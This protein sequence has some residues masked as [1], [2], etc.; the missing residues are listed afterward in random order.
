[1]YIDIPD[2]SNLM[3]KNGYWLLVGLLFFYVLSV[4]KVYILAR[5][6]ADILNNGIEKQEPFKEFFKKFFYSFFSEKKLHLLTFKFLLKYRKKQWP[7]IDNKPVKKILKVLTAITTFLKP[8]IVFA[9]IFWI[10]RVWIDSQMI[11]DPLT[12]SLGSI[13]EKLYLLRAMPKLD[14]VI[15]YKALIYLFIGIG[16]IMLV[17][18]SKSDDVQKK[19]KKYY[20]YSFACLAILMNVSFFTVGFAAS[21]SNAHL[22][23]TTL[24]VEII[25]VHNKIY[26]YAAEAVTV[27]AI[28]KYIGDIQDANNKEAIRIQKEATLQNSDSYDTVILNPYLRSIA[29]RLDTYNLEDVLN[30]S[31]FDLFPPP[32][33]VFFTDPLIP[34]PAEQHLAS[35]KL[36]DEASGLEID[37]SIEKPDFP[38]GTKTPATIIDDHYDKYIEPVN[39]DAG[40]D[41]YFSE[42]NN[43]N[44]QESRDILADITLVRNA[45]ITKSKKLTPKANQILDLIFSCGLEMGLDKLFEPYYLKQQKLLKK[46]TSA[47]LDVKFKDCF[48]KAT[49]GLM[50]RTK[51]K[52]SVTKASA[53]C[54]I[55]SPIVEN[56]LEGK[57]N[58]D[59]VIDEKVALERRKTDL[60]TQRKNEHDEQVRIERETRLE[61]ERIRKCHEQYAQLEGVIK[62]AVQSKALGIP[63]GYGERITEYLRENP[64]TLVSKEAM[65]QMLALGQY[66]SNVTLRDNVNRAINSIS[67]GDIKKIKEDLNAYLVPE[68]GSSSIV[69]YG[70]LL[71][72]NYQLVSNNSSIASIVTGVGRRDNINSSQFMH[73]FPDLCSCCGL[74]RKFPVC[75]CELRLR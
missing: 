21:V 66:N 67:S 1:M 31:S 59:W 19:V 6:Q 22:K 69:Q 63:N 57:S 61:Q 14:I 10:L 2:L 12:I 35:L 48:V 54:N 36:F 49:V 39:P 23:L 34:V 38:K 32:D 60:I 40:Y 27:E 74:P 4:M 11:Y 46:I 71:I 75:G 45:A 70:E 28:D 15:A 62:D 64:N 58:S 37:P 53:N 44:L 55:G 16:I 43:W 9:F 18:L 65:R 41:A 33:K 73:F 30:V 20:T 56:I 25:K 26:T 72:K 47:L 52:L 17:S 51:A 7:E 24:T 68:V 5:V 50:A 13:Q 42:K 3:L 29:Q 8:F